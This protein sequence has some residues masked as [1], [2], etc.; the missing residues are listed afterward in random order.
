[1]ALKD[2]LN[3]IQAVADQEVEKMQ[4]DFEKAKLDLIAQFDTDTK[5]ELEVLTEKSKEAG[6]AVEK[7]VNTMAHR[8]CKQ[9]LLET[10]R[11]LL[12]K[13]MDQFMDSLVALPSDEKEKIYQKLAKNITATAGEAKVAKGD[14]T[15]VK[16]VLASGIEIKEDGDL[17]GGFILFS[18]GS[19]MDCSFENLLHSEYKNELEMYFSDQLKLV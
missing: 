12:D 19:E 9:L 14:I 10:K 3:K 5:K 13:A 16:S 2:I 11:S 18:E 1:M 15:V 17:K 4:H 7:K 6:K 8:D